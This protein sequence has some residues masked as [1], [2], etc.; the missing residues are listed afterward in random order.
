MTKFV[1][2]S[3]RAFMFMSGILVG[4]ALMKITYPENNAKYI[5]SNDIENLSPAY[6]NPVKLEQKL[7][8]LD[9]NGSQEYV[10]EYEGKSYL[11]LVGEDGKPECKEYWVKP[12][13]I[14][15]K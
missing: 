12:K 11:F 2:Y 6:V 8:D 5:P 14:V 3:K 4:A 13:E 15:V 7:I 1:D 10:L 9:G